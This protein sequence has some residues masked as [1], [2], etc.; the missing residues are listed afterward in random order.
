MSISCNVSGLQNSQKTQEFAF[1]VYKPKKPEVQI[2]IISTNDQNYAYAMYRKRVNEKNIVIERLS[3]TSVLFHIKSLEE[4]DSGKYEC[5]TPNTDFRY[6]GSY[7]ADTTLNGNLF[8]Y[9]LCSICLVIKYV[10]HNV[11]GIVS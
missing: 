1:S 8:Y 9:S 5:E 11:F 6:F 4:E 10:S 2:L 3:S 7:S